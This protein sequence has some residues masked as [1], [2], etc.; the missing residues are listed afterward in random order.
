[1]GETSRDGGVKWGRSDMH[2]A[3]SESSDKKIRLRTRNIGK[4]IHMDRY[5]LKQFKSHGN[6]NLSVRLHL[7]IY[8]LLHLR[9]N[10]AAYRGNLC[11][12]ALC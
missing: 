6:S 11:V 7:L 8:S 5:I 12:E 2:D 9:M 4:W 1:M 10:Y 3:A